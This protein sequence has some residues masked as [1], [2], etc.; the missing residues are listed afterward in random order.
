MVDG[1]R[2]LRTTA[3]AESSAQTDGAGCETLGFA[4]AGGL[5]TATVVGCV[6]FG[7]GCGTVDGGVIDVVRIARAALALGTA[8]ADR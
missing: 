5:A 3:G 8:V 4:T 7:S 2:R 6:L 1:I